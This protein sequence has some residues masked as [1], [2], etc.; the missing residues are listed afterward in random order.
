MFNY[1]HKIISEEEII[2]ILLSSLEKRRSPYINPFSFMFCHSVRTVESYS[3]VYFSKMVQ[4]NELKLERTGKPGDFDIL[5]IP[6]E[7][8]DIL[9]ERT[10][11]IEVKVVRP[12]IKN[13]SRNANSFG[14]TQINGLIEDGFPLIG[15]IHICVPEPTPKNDCSQIKYLSDKARNSEDYELVKYDWFPHSAVKNQKRR[16][17]SFNL[18]TFVNLYSSSLSFRENGS[19]ELGHDLEID[20]GEK[21]DFN[22]ETKAEAI[23]KIKEHFDNYSASKY[24]KVEFTNV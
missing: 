19:C 2:D 24:T 20:I 21:G 10:G 16:L 4:R 8:K 5:L 23:K 15:L 12:T 18:P 11:V 7:G 9:F 1:I 22:P 14:I 3:G 6:Y 17:I 13:P